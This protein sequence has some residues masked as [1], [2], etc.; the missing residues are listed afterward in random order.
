MCFVHDPQYQKVSFT[1]ALRAFRGNHRVMRWRDGATAGEIVAGGKGAGDMLDQ[2]NLPSGI[3]LE[4]GGDM[5]IVD[6]G[7]H[8][9]MRWREGST[10]GEIVA[11]GKGAGNML[12]QLCMPNPRNPCPFEII[13]SG[14][15]C[16]ITRTRY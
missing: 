14:R 15:N 4:W 5:L 12:D 3:A 1:P 9:V 6:T 2:L 8:R 7:N 13:E 11:G 10:A 16:V